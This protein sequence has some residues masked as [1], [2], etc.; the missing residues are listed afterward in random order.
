MGGDTGDLRGL[1][2]E[3][4]RGLIE[5]KLTYSEEVTLD[6]DGRVDFRVRRNVLR[7][8]Y[9]LWQGQVDGR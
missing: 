1:L 3:S 5:Q 2:R 9:T 8:A 4:P 7:N 6:G